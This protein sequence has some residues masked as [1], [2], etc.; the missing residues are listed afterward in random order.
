MA[1]DVDVGNENAQVAI[2]ALRVVAAHKNTMG[3]CKSYIPGQLTGPRQGGEKEAHYL[4]RLG[5]PYC[6]NEDCGDE[7][8]MQRR[9]HSYRLCVS[10]QT[11]LE[12]K[13]K[14]L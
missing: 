9:E 12:H 4:A 14:G 11:K 13:Q 5:D 10:C 8:P 2:D 3:R 1:D 7:I 6:A